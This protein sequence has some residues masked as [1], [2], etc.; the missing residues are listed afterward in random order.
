MPTPAQKITV[1][2]RSP[3]VFLAS[4]RLSQSFDLTDNLFLMCAPLSGLMSQ[5][6]LARA[7][8]RKADIADEEGVLDTLSG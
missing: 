7:T 2:D 8:D 6:L 3:L 5:S 4:G 1:L